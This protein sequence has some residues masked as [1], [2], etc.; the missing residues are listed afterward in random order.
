[1]TVFILV[2]IRLEPQKIDLAF[3]QWVGE[4]NIPLA[5]VFTKADKLS[6][7]QIMYSVE[8]YKKELKKTWEEL[9]L[10]FITSSEKKEGRE[11]LLDYLEATNSVFV[12]P[13]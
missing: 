4:N 7:Q 11:E 6:K 3:I 1:M 9:P 2:D 5:I 8:G 10:L 13:S 12:K